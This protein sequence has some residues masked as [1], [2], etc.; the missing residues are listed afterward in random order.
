MYEEVSRDNPSFVDNIT[1]RDLDRVRR[2]IYNVKRKMFPALPKSREEAIGLL[3][4]LHLKT[5]K[6]EEF[7]I[8]CDSEKQIEIFS[9]DTNLKFMCKCSRLY[10]DGT[11]EYCP[12]YWTQMFSI[13]AL[14]NGN[15]IPIAFALLPD[16]K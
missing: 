12:K 5:V 9:T 10:V 16:K 11:F 1:N 8:D 13:H 6:E 2:N 4:T 7:L 3:Q 15:Y 14:E